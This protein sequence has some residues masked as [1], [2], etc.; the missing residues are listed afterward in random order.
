MPH[1]RKG[2]VNFDQDYI[3][4]LTICGYLR[5]II[6]DKVDYNFVISIVHLYHK[7]G[8]AKC[9]DENVDINYKQNMRFADMV[10]T[11]NRIFAFS[12]QTDLLKFSSQNR[13]KVSF[14]GQN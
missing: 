5:D 10:K 12:I 4:K 7:Q 11:S 13:F 8:F 2:A 3:Q 14:H 6:N 1:Q 9:F